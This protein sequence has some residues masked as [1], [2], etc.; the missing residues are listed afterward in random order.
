MTMTSKGYQEV[1]HEN[2]YLEKENNTL[3]HVNTMYKIKEELK[4]DIDKRISW[5]IKIGLIISGFI[6]VGSIAG[7]FVIYSQV[8]TMVRNK[9][10]D[11]LQEPEIKKTVTDV[12][13]SHAKNLI[14]S[15]VK[16]AIDEVNTQ[17][18]LA[19]KTI[20][21]S[22]STLTDKFQILSSKI[23]ESNNYIYQKIDASSD[24]KSYHALELISKE[25]RSAYR[26]NARTTISSIKSGI[27]RNIKNIFNESQSYDLLYGELPKARP[28]SWNLKD[29]SDNYDDLTALGK[30]S[31]LVILRKRQSGKDGFETKRYLQFLIEKLKTEEDLYSVYKICSMIDEIA[32]LNQKDY[33]NKDPF[34]GWYEEHIKE[35][36]NKR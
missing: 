7:I 35:Q 16:V 34:L 28:E 29:F 13:T 15:K 4:N 1:V 33:F 6:G 25:E 2:E 14:E 10:E 26:E 23:D 11:K 8:N 18:E 19:I 3:R 12:A 21:V 17:A 22:N 30:V 27:I 36:D 5:W 31:L 24:Y 20:I 9:V 32:G